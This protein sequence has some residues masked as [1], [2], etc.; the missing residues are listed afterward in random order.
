MAAI[1]KTPRV[2]NYTSLTCLV[3]CRLSLL[4]LKASST[5]YV[6]YED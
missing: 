6:R 3:P 4:G 2:T 5:H 1:L